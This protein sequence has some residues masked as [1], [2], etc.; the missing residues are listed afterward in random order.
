[1]MDRNLDLSAMEDFNAKDFREKISRRQ[2]AQT[3]MDLCW[4]IDQLNNKDSDL[5]YQDLIEKSSLMFN[6]GYVLSLK[7]AEICKA[8][9]KEENRTKLD[10]EILDDIFFS[11]DRI[12]PL[13]VKRENMMREHCLK[14]TFVPPKQE[15]DLDDPPKVSMAKVFGR[16]DKDFEELPNCALPITSDLW[17]TNA[18]GDTIS[19]I[20]VDSKNGTHEEFK[21]STKIVSKLVPSPYLFKGVLELN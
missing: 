9:F 16:K 15:D 1:M 18:Y 2:I 6:T 10:K 13:Y 3:A 5:R 14:N 19:D 21:R 7:A 4:S 17:E 11:L 8:N 20:V 12:D